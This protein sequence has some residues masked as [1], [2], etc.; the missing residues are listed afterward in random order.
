MQSRSVRKMDLHEFASDGHRACTDGDNV[1]LGLTK[2]MDPFRFLLTAVSGW[3]NQQ[4]LRL[5]DYLL[6]ENRVLREQLGQKRTRFNDDQHRRLGVKRPPRSPTFMTRS[7]FRTVS[8]RRGWPCRRRGRQTQ[9]AGSRVHEA[10]TRPSVETN[11]RRTR[12]R[13]PRA[14]RKLRR[15]A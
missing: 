12:I 11:R 5:I 7:I 3:M 6:E 2:S 4:Q 14:A 13:K 15:R 1:T 9:I 10:R 8:G